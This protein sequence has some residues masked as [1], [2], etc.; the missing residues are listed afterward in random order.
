M[1]WHLLPEYLPDSD[2]GRQL[3]VVRPGAHSSCTDAR[4]DGSFTVGGAPVRDRGHP[5]APSPHVASSHTSPRLARTRLHAGTGAR[6]RGERTPTPSAGPRA[7][8]PRADRRPGA[9]CRGRHDARRTRGCAAGPRPG[10]ARGHAPPGRAVPAT[11]GAPCVLRRSN[12]RGIL[13]A[14]RRLLGRARSGGHSS[15]SRSTTFR[16]RRTPGRRDAR[17]GASARR[18]RCG[19]P[20]IHVGHAGDGAVGTRTRAGRRCARARPEG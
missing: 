11:H 10:P 12:G 8:P 19:E 5:Q 2:A 4:S 16:H 15:A 20:G 17:V 6:R 18:I 7:P 9:G 13:G 14:A 1:G 3:C